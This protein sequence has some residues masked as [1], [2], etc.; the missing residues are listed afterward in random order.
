MTAIET[1]E[2]AISEEWRPVVG[3][4]GKYEVSS[5]GRIRSLMRKGS[6]APILKP[7]EK[8]GYLYVKIGGKDRRVHRL[9]A[10][11]FLQAETGKPVVRHLDGNRANNEV[12]NLAWGTSSEN[13]LDTIAH[14]RHT[15]TNKTH[16]N[17]GHEFAEGNIY[18]NRGKRQCRACW[19]ARMLEHKGSLEVPSAKKTHCKSGHE[20]T[21][22]NTYRYLRNG[23]W[24]RHCRACQSISHQNRRT[25]IAKENDNDR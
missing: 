8:H 20:F 9:V 1:L 4:E 21:P 24:R 15:N 25:R 5:L 3:F 17:R 23:S 22:E 13:A 2:R 10:A 12:T 11:A 19:R 7:F 14:G 18:W 6:P 16:C